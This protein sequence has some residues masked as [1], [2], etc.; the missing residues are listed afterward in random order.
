MAKY[1][2]KCNVNKNVSEFYKNKDHKDGLSSFCK[3]CMLKTNAAYKK[4]KKGK[5]TRDKSNRKYRKTEEGKEYYKNYNTSSGRRNRHL[6]NKFDITLEQYDRM[7]DGQ[8]GVCAICGRPERAVTKHGFVKH[9]AVD[10][11][12]RT[13]K[14]R[15]LLCI[16]CNLKVGILEDREWRPLARKYLYDNGS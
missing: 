12:H 6:V 14:V 9:L 4:T 2:R 13:G 11:D 16:R 15:G 8:K 10:H 5:K 7:L 3:K 1:C